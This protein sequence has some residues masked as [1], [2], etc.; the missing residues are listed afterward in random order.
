MNFLK[1]TF[2][3][4]TSKQWLL[5]TIIFII[6]FWGFLLIAGENDSIPI[7]QWLAIKTFGLA[8]FGG[9]IKLGAIL[10]KKGLLPTLKEED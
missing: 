10:D 4:G 6:G 3:D 5:A 8:L 1:N 2:G 9:S 7:L